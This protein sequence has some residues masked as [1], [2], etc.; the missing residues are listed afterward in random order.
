VRAELADCLERCRQVL[1]PRT[2]GTFCLY[3]L[4]DVPA[5]PTAATVEMPV[6]QVYVTRHQVIQRLRRLMP[7][8][9]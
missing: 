9:D 2:L 4:A 1:A 6:N 7:E 5:A 8:P 3:A